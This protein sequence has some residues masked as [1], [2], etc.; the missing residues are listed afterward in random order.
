LAVIYPGN[1]IA[2][3]AACPQLGA[4]TQ[5]S[6]LEETVAN[7]REAAALAAEDEPEF[8]GRP[9]VVTFAIDLES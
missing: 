2:Y 6:T 8:R 3:V 7:L 9:L 4:F 5:G 1:E